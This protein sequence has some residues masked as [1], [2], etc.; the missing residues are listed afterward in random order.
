MQ[1]QGEKL[2]KRLNPREL[3][4]NQIPGSS[5]S[6]YNS[7]LLFVDEGSQIFA[8]VFLGLE[9]LRSL[10]IRSRA[11]NRSVEGVRFIEV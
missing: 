10:E 4:P 1:N 7:L 3:P 8:E 6:R 5:F 2:I 9:L 11:I